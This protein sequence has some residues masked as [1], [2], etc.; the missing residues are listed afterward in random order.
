MSGIISLATY[1]PETRRS[2]QEIAE[3]HSVSVERL[4][5][6]GMHSVVVAGDDD[7]PSTMAIKASRR[8]LEAAKVDPADLALV[9]FAGA[10]K[11]RPAP[12]VAAFQVAQ[13][14]GSKRATSFDLSSRCCGLV[15]SIWTASKLVHGDQYALVCAAD[16]FDHLFESGSPN[17][18]P[19]HLQYGAGGAAVVI[20][21][22]VHNSVVAAHTSANDFSHQSET[23]AP[24][25]GGTRWPLN[26]AA[27]AESAHRYSDTTPLLQSEALA[28]WIDEVQEH[29]LAATCGRAEFARI[30]F[31]A[32][33]CRNFPSQQAYL[34]ERG[35]T[36]R[37]YLFTTPVHGHL[38]ASAVVA[39]LEAAMRL[40][41]AIGPQ[42]I[43][44]GQT[45]TRTSAVAVRGTTA[46]LG[47][48]IAAQSCMTA[49][50]LDLLREMHVT[51][52]PAEESS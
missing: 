35:F 18:A 25:A 8:A 13:H 47:I 32:A 19:L 1:L 23:H 9:I 52:P 48:R 49:T 38:G 31:L 33:L 22:T 11:D 21:P 46:D 16:R 28:R 14:L 20:G 41:L 40:K 17:I 50:E 24:L 26:E 10:N 12:W 27:L 29:D 3:R 37:Q 15:D 30:D 2:I 42:L 34:S 39:N 5:K 45:Y 43:A 44:Y 36:E 4:A 51:K 7:H 6:L